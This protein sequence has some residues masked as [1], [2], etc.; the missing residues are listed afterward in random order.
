MRL[1]VRDWPR[2]DGI[3]GLD[4]CSLDSALQQILA[5]MASSGLSRHSL[6]WGG[7]IS[8]SSKLPQ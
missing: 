1:L 4:S 2:K 8:S 6:A 5:V 3:G 7:A